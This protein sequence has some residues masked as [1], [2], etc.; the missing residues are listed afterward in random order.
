MLTEIQKQDGVRMEV[1]INQKKIEKNQ[2]SFGM[3]Y[4]NMD[5]IHLSTIFC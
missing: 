2:Q 4:K 5:G 3:L 1:V